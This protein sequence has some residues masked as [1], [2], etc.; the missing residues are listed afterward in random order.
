MVTVCI[1][2]FEVIGELRRERLHLSRAAAFSWN[3]DNFC[4]QRAEHLRRSL[5]I[6]CREQGQWQASFIWGKLAYLTE[7]SVMEQILREFPN[8]RKSWED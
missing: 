7:V 5:V 1:A 8:S 6:V 2:S 4:K 3:M